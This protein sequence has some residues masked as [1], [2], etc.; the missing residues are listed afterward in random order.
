MA[1]EKGNKVEGSKKISKISKGL[2]TQKEVQR[3]KDNFVFV[4]IIV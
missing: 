1:C 4:L 2:E 3:G